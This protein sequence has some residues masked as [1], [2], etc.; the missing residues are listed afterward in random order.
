M[1]YNKIFYVK[2]SGKV[3]AC[4]FEELY[5]WYDRTAESEHYSPLDSCRVSYCLK[6]ADGSNEM[7]YCCG[8][9]KL[10]ATVDDC[11]NNVYVEQPPK[12][13]T[14]EILK[15][16]IGFVPEIE[17][18]VIQG[19]GC[20]YAHYKAWMWNGYEPEL[21]CIG[22]GDGAACRSECWYNA[23]TRKFKCRKWYATREECAKDNSIEVI[24]FENS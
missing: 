20:R 21:K 10:S 6:L 12:Y 14:P 1:D 2:R 5:F 7:G 11:L 13:L 16:A 23:L 19:L 3:I 17:R 24:N 4:K 15:E 9:P 18:G 8:F 22:Y